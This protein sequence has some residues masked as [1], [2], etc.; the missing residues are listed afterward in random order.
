MQLR[1]WIR[2]T[3]AALA[4]AAL[5]GAG[6]L[7]PVAADNSATQQI[8]APTGGALSASI[9]DFTFTALQYSASDRNNAGVFNLTASDTR[10]TGAGWSVSVQSG[11]F[12][13]G[14]SPIQI[15]A[16]NLSIT[17]ANAPAVSSG[18]PIDAT[19]G[20]FV[21]SSGATGALSSPHTVVAA[22]QHFGNGT[23]TQALDVNLLVPGGTEIG[24][25]TAN[26]TVSVTATGP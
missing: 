10:G 15:P 26:L 19:G 18:Q 14:G 9:A 13:A 2:Q 17:T 7:S 6:L 1:H 21:P 25:Y 4:A 8:T 5:L 23:Y 22:A 11:A 12:T 20:P 16:A 24:T 3:S